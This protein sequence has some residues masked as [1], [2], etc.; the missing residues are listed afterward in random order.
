M[1][2]NMKAYP[3]FLVA[4]LLCGGLSSPALASTFTSVVFEAATEANAN[5]NPIPLPNDTVSHPDATHDGFSAYLSDSGFLN[6]GAKYIASGEAIAPSAGSIATLRG[7]ASLQLLS[8][9][10]FQDQFASLYVFSQLSTPITITSSL[11]TPGTGLVDLAADLSVDG[12]V[13]IAGAPLNP[14]FN[15]AVFFSIFADLSQ[16]SQTFLSGTV[17]QSYSQDGFPAFK[18]QFPQISVTPGTYQL[19]LGIEVRSSIA[20]FHNS[21]GSDVLFASGDFS[22]TIQLLGFTTD[23]PGVSITAAD[24]SPFQIFDSS[25]A[26][27]PEPGSAV[28]MFCGLTALCVRGAARLKC[29]RS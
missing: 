23:Q 12:Q 7:S 21:P 10:I 27:V 11:F 22:H 1:A 2:K 19:Q 8:P 17:G 4:F 6:D 9:S 5:S 3:Q 24:G 28:L 16:G 15:N 13:S 25:P 18:P 14:T 20:S 29:R 26:S